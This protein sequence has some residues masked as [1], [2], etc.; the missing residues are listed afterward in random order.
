MLPWALG[1]AATRDYCWPAAMPD[2]TPNPPAPPPLTPPAP[3]IAAAEAAQSPGQSLGRSLPPPPPV[4]PPAGD[5]AALR[6]EIDR[7]DSALHDLLM[8]RAGLSAHMAAS[9]AKGSASSF[10]PGREAAILRRLLSRHAG[11]LPRAVVVRLWRDVISSSLAQ[12]GPFNMAAP[13]SA[14]G[15]EAQLARGHFGLL[16]PL[17]LY[18]TPSRVLSAVASGEATVAIMPAPGEGEP[19]E[20]AWW[21]QM[22][23]PRLQ[24]VAGLPFLATREGAEPKAFVVAPIV[25]EP[26]GRD[27][28]LLRLEPEAEHTRPRIAAA[29]ASIG[30]P[31]RWLLRRDL[32]NPMALAE[33]QGFL[34]PDDPRLA[35]LPFQRIQILGAYA[36]PETEDLPA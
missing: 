36:E 1:V 26:T 11:P 14:E 29:F 21:V 23:A 7:I 5:L 8:Q 24:V 30:L 13:G 16:T 6:E 25:P 27:R 15:V 17:K 2:Q 19:P 28:T 12:Q 20:A 31:T 4:L 22:E 34:A 33:V 32:P 18:P 9:R 3:Q 35:S 10:R